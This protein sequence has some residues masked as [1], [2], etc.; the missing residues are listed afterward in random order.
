[1]ENEMNLLDFSLADEKTLHLLPEDDL[2][3]HQDDLDDYK[4][5]TKRDTDWENDG[6]HSKFLAH[7]RAKI[8][9]MPQHNGKTSVGLERAIAYLKRLDKEISRAIQSDDKNIIDEQEAEDM[10]DMISDYIDKLEDGLEKLTSKKR[11]RRSS[12]KIASKV[13]GR[14]NASGDAE[15]YVKAEID[16]EEMLLQVDLDEPS[17]LAVQAY[18]DWEA[19]KLTKSASSA[20]IMLM[21]DP[22]LHEIT[23]IIMKSHIT[24]GRDIE[25]VYGEL[26]KKYAFSP[27]DHLAV[28]SLLREKG[29][30]L[31]RDFSTIG[32]E[33]TTE[34]LPVGTE[35][36]PG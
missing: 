1:M 11:G 18:M 20:K 25:S 5:D 27:R 33:L 7:M 28:H 2:V 35:S 3:V 26:A 14:I 21:A 32:E 30:L 31:D 23:N 6:D 22:F 10:R 29:L 4:L 34:T 36:Y 15:H 12:V 19:G 13:F 9:Q 8:K 16:G 17:D 24:F